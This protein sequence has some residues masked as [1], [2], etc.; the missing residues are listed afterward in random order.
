MVLFNRVVDFATNNSVNY[1]KE[2]EA[3]SLAISEIESIESL[4]NYYTKEDGLNDYSEVY[5]K[6]RV[7]IIELNNQII[8]SKRNLAQAKTK[9]DYQRILKRIDYLLEQLEIILIKAKNELLKSKTLGELQEHLTE[10][11]V[12][13]NSNARFEPFM[14]FVSHGDWTVKDLKNIR[15]QIANRRIKI[16]PYLGNNYRR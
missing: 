9:L 8:I 10:L 5:K 4:L 14:N 16:I 2:N 6:I 11:Q 7:E 1:Q 12:I 13:I 3:Y 15:N